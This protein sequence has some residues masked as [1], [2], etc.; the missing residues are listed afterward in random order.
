MIDFSQGAQPLP[1]YFVQ[2]ET[3][4]AY[5]EMRCAERSYIGGAHDASGLPFERRADVAEI[6]R[7]RLL[8]E[9]YAGLTRNTAAVLAEHMRVAQLHDLCMTPN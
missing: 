9:L 5:A 4:I 8:P 7:R 3:R 1:N 6:V 2:L